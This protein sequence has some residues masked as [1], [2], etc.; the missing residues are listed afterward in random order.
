MTADL[1][2]DDRGNRQDLHSAGA[3]ALAEPME[4]QA[5]GRG[6]ALAMSL[7]APTWTAFVFLTFR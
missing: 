6:L 4:I 7:S 3:A 5:F 2:I 1:L